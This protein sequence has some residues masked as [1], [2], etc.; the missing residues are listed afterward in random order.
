MAKNTLFGPLSLLAGVLIFSTNGFWQ[1][2]APEGNTPYVVGASRLVIGGITLSLWCL[3]RYGKI[4]L[5]GWD[6]KAITIYAVALWL[7]QIFFFQGVHLIGVA[8]GTVIAVGST[9]IFAGLI[10]A[11]LYK[12]KP[13]LLWYIATLL[14]IAGL[15]LV[16]MVDGV[17]FVW[18]A[19][20]L[21]PGFA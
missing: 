19:V 14:A 11:F 21:P 9:P 12:D 17:D 3:I 18:Y 20:I 15:V 2:I 5:H 8:V 16:N 7:Y 6:W 1:A 10:Q 13:D 4:R